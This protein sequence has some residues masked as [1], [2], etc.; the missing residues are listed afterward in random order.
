MFLNIK[1]GVTGWIIA[2]FP[3]MCKFGGSGWKMSDFVCAESET[4]QTGIFR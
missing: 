1:T 2:S 4:L 3:E